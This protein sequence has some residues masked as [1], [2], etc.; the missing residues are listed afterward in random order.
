M[1]RGNHLYSWSIGTDGSGYRSG[2]LCHSDLEPRNKPTL[3]KFFED[4]DVKTIKCGRH[5]YYFLLKDGTLYGCGSNHLFQL[6]I[7]S[8]Y[9]EKRRWEI[10]DITSVPYVITTGVNKIYSPGWTEHI[11]I[12]NNENEILAIGT[13]GCG[14]IGNGGW[15]SVERPTV[16]TFFNDKEIKEIQLQYWATTV[17]YTE[18]D[19]EKISKEDEEIEKLKPQ[20]KLDIKYDPKIKVNLNIL[21]EKE[22]EKEK[23]KEKET[24]KETEKEIEKEKE[25][26]KE[27]KKIKYATTGPDGVVAEFG[28]IELSP[29]PN[30]DEMDTKQ[31]ICGSEFCF[32]R[33]NKDQFF[34]Y[35]T[36][37]KFE[38]FQQ[39]RFKYSIYKL[40][41]EIPK[42]NEHT[43]FFAGNHFSLFITQLPEY[44]KDLFEISK[45]M[46]IAKVNK[47]FLKLRL[48]NADSM[49]KI[50]KFVNGENKEIFFKWLYGGK[51]LLVNKSKQ[52][53]KILKKLLL[54]IG[55]ENKQFYI[56]I[57]EHMQYLLNNTD[58][59]D[60]EIKIKNETFTAHSWFLSARSKFFAK[61]IQTKNEN[62]NEN[63]NEK[64]N[65]NENENQEKEKKKSLIKYFV[66]DTSGFSESTFRNVLKLI[67]TGK[68]SI[69]D[70]NL[71]VKA[72]IQRTCAFYE[73][74]GKNTIKGN[75]KL[76]E[77]KIQ[78]RKQM[79]CHVCS[80]QG[81]LFRCSRCFKV[82]Y[83]SV[84]CQ[85]KDWRK[86]KNHCK[87]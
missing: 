68:L 57:Q 66:T 42:I 84:N 32:L 10:Q 16:Q 67:Y 40:P 69:E 41:F 27:E 58:N 65:E 20:I 71:T 72:E 86:H 18:K 70:F 31:L 14:Q 1:D 80:K 28:S 12:R 79:K 63:E 38:T 74:N 50:S 7:K 60:T 64:K 35:G 44:F 4:K 22:T 29:K 47:E 83:C 30:F 33:N 13:N 23:E 19:A 34:V 48:G 87:K 61:L 37:K 53:I 6:G 24:E 15:E 78:K 81:E 85:R 52:E 45:E 39:E 11:F 75:L 3:I 25:T 21:G 26:K 59:H 77:E 54:G 62:E 56:P 49:E 36:P 8:P 9:D 51:L 76:Y 82:V 46:E 2:Q 17:L 55:V 73:M 43:N 5:S